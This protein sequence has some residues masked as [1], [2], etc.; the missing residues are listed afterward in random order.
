[1][2][3]IFTIAWKDLRL[4]ARDR[5]GMFFMLAFPIAMGIVFGMIGVRMSSGEPGVL[6]IPLVDLDGTP[7]S[8]QL[9]DA[10]DQHAQL[11]IEAVEE[12]AARDLVRR[13]K[14]SAMIV[15][16]SGYGATAGLFWESDPPEIKILAD[17]SRGAESAMLQGYLF[18]ASGKLLGSRFQNPESYRPH[19]RKL[20]D[21]L[22]ASSESSLTKGALRTMLGSLDQFFVDLSASQQEAEDAGSDQTEFEFKLANVTIEPVTAEKSKSEQT[23]EKIRSPWDISFPSAMLWGVLATASGF[24]ISLV[25]E[26]S[27]GTFLRLQAAPIA[28][29]QILGGKALACFLAVLLV[30][31]VLAALAIGLGMR[32][33]NYPMLLVAGL[34][35]AACFVG[36]MLTIS[37]I[38][39]SEEAVGGAAWGANV[40]MAMFGGGMIP[41]A[42]MPDFFA[43]ISNFSPV[44]WAIL[45]LEGAIWREFSWSE[46]LVPLTVLVGIGVAGSILGVALLRRTRA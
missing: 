6:K 30:M 11:E 13:G 25:R 45:A 32:P 23:I 41:L 7:E 2:S 36:V 5:L 19:V 28:H 34:A 46:M 21:D 15:V 31:S 16:P 12:Q 14:R 27:R 4:V 42:F 29:W 43:R 22:D 35:I 24:A 1:M 18:E 26:R 8:Q 44:K 40:M 33:K 3:S 37:N 38:G 9:R 17:P 10:L 39:K 20:I